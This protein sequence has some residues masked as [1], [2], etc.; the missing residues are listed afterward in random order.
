MKFNY[1]FSLKIPAPQA[2]VKLVEHS[3]REFLIDLPPQWNQIP[4]LQD[5]TFNYTSEVDQASITISV[6]FWEIPESKAHVIA[7]K[8]MESRL[9]ALEQVYPDRVNVLNQSTKPHSGGIG[10]EMNLV[11]E[12]PDENTYIYLGY[13]TSRKIFNFTLVC[14]SD[15]TMAS[16]LFNT[17]VENLRVKLP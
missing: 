16:S 7:D 4:T 15:T 2:P 9:R 5:N 8:A 6:D 1:S 13:V 14:K 17:I 3:Y 12:V 10:L 11:I